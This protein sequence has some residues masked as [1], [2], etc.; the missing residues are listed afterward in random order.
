MFCGCYSYC[1]E[2]SYCCARAVRWESAVTT[3][4]L[5]VITGAP[6][7]H[8]HAGSIITT[9]HKGPSMGIT[10]IPSAVPAIVRHTKA[11][12]ALARNPGPVGDNILPD[13]VIAPWS[14]R[15]RLGMR[16]DCALAV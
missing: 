15:H 4:I 8:T 16:P 9:I 5:R 14:Y 13:T 11:I 1:W 10:T 3:A 12:I 2:C 6:T 7:T